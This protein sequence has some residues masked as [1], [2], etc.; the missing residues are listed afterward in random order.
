MVQICGGGLAIAGTGP[1]RLSGAVKIVSNIAGEGGGGAVCT[2]ADPALSEAAES[3]TLGSVDVN[4]I[5]KSCTDTPA[6]YGIKDDWTAAVTRT[7][8]VNIAKGAQAMVPFPALIV[9]WASTR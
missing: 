4:P 8:L 7:F 9:C 1:V 3:G 2:I 6:G 5:P